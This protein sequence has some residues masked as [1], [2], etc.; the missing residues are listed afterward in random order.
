[1]PRLP[2]PGLDKGTW[3]NVLNDYLQQAHN[4][5][6]DLKSNVVGSA[7][8]AANSVTTA[9]LSADIQSKLNT[10]AV[11]VA[12]G[13]IGTAQLSD[14]AVTIAKLAA[15]VQASITR[16]DSAVQTINSKTGQTITLAAAD[17]GLGNVTNTSDANKPIS[18]ATQAALNL[19]ATTA[20]LSAVATSG[21]YTDLANKPIIPVTSVAGRTGAIV[22][23]KS[24]VDLINVD[25]TTD[26]A[27]P[28][29]TAV[30]NALNA[31]AT[32][33]SLAA[34]AT[35]GNYN[36]LINI[37]T[38]SGTVSSVAGRAGAV[39]LTSADVGLANVDNTSDL[40]KPL[41]TAAQTAINLKANTSSLS[42][43]ATTGVYT[44]LTARPTI[45]T[46]AA[47][48]GA[49]A[50]AD[51]DSTVAT[52]ITTTNT[53]TSN[54]LNG[55]YATASA[56]TAKYTKPGT[57]I[58]LTDLAT[59]IQ[60]ELTSSPNYI[61]VAKTVNTSLSSATTVS[62]DPHLTVSV[63]ANGK[64]AFEMLLAYE[65]DVGVG[66]KLSFVAP[67]G[68]TIFGIGFGV[69]S[70]NAAT[71][72]PGA[73]MTIQYVTTANSAYGVA[74]AVGAG[75]GVGYRISGTLTT[76]ANAG[77]FGLAWAQGTSSGVP[78]ILY[79]GSE[80]SVTKVG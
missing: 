43:V 8:L 22:L 67:A 10:V 74:G 13:T 19:K 59:P 1:M 18:T 61:R 79:T 29:S 26:L 49:V 11:G 70:T 23:T 34:I 33:S 16:A 38:G 64:Y 36:D 73:A 3:G 56:V 12:D 69:G 63:A 20:N 50:T 68:Y 46:T 7:Q 58:P 6:G 52:N 77:T 60:A 54:A 31:K 51:L 30:Q 35:T 42:T 41:S 21:S 17:L 75:T 24:D 9:A 66:I 40:N 14:A 62:N 48:V 78:T 28:I 15:S 55:L 57:G 76:A 72:I 80:L 71:T 53:S 32:A 4:A 39:T 44:D 5:N 37:P 47:Q 65:A 45:P 25:N 27:K 2:Q